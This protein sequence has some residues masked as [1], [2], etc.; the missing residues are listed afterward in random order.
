MIPSPSR[1]RLIAWSWGAG[2]F[3]LALSVNLVTLNGKGWLEHPP[4]PG[5]SQDYYNI[6]LNVLDGRGFGVW[7][8]NPVFRSAYEAHNDDGRYRAVLRRHG[9]YEP[10]TYRP[11]LLPLT[12]AGLFAVAGPDL[13]VWLGFE[14][15]IVAAA[16][17]LAALMALRIAGHLAASLTALLGSFDPFRSQFAPAGLTE[18][19]T[20]LG[21]IGLAWLLVR[22][23]DGRRPLLALASG[24][25]A[26]ALVLGR[27]IFLLW[28]PL[29]VV[30]LAWC[31]KRTGSRTS[32]W[33]VSGLFLLPA[34]V[35][36]SPWW[37]R[38]CIVLDR[39]MPLGTQGGIGLP[40]GYSDQ[41][42]ESGG[43][44]SSTERNLFWT[45]ARNRIEAAGERP[46]ADRASRARYG[47]R[48]VLRWIA[49]HPAELPGLALRKAWNSWT[50]V[51]RHGWLLIV[52]LPGLLLVRRRFW[53]VV[54]WALLAINTAAIAATYFALGRFQIPTVL[55]LDLLAAV[56]LCAVVGWLGGPSR[57][58][59]WAVTPP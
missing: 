58:V 6:A 54:P 39:F 38:N 21:V 22:L 59:R 20:M 55:L 29:L 10:T 9:D 34:I 33:L 41:A 8:D 13:R 28:L 43:L 50:W 27:P 16:V 18:G 23:T 12:M 32:V 24:A 40:V 48:H 36:P 52:A 44:W 56:S 46:L 35:I 19:L 31:W 3:L 37:V 11:P 15:A 47:R 49:A 17:A 53:I 5:D 26:G 51:P 45:E 57:P 14:A 1:K 30:L 25:V 2:A 4:E 7:W 42:L